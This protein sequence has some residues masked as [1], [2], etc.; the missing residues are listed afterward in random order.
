MLAAERVLLMSP[1]H[2]LRDQV[3]QACPELG[4]D[5]WD[6]AE[7]GPGRQTTTLRGSSLT[8]LRHMVMAG[9]GVTVL[10][11]TAIAPADARQLVLRPLCPVEERTVLLAW[12]RGY[13]RKAALDVL[14][15][16]AQSAAR[17]LGVRPAH[18]DHKTS[19]L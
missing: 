16:T 12:R 5:A 1:G 2:C 3:L 4:R 8:T 17:T 9:S 6:A 14:V 7:L 19:L 15:A 13:P 10:P 11:A 18:A